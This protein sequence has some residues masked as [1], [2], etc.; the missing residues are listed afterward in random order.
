MDREQFWNIID[1][2]LEETNG[3]ATNAV[4]YANEQLALLTPSERDDWWSTYHEI[5][6]LMLEVQASDEWKNAEDD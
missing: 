1:S 2:A 6:D 5:Y 4:K 3:N